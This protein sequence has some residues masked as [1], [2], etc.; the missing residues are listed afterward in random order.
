MRTVNGVEAVERGDAGDDAADEEGEAGAGCG[1][2]SDRGKDKYAK[3]VGHAIVTTAE[4]EPAKDAERRA[5]VRAKVNFFACV[6]SEKFEDDVVTCIDMAKG[7]VSF[8][9]RNCYEPDAAISIAVPFAAEEREAP[10]ILVNGRITNVK[11]LANVEMY[12]CGVEFV[13]S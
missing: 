3:R 8:R 4:P 13:K 1:G 7:G 10:A 5:R 2:E 11:K 6:R 9:N 12:R